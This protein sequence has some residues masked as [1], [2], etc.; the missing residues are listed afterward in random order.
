MNVMNPWSPYGSG[1]V[2]TSTLSAYVSTLMVVVAFSV[3]F[4]M[5]RCSN[6]CVTLPRTAMQIR[7]A[8]RPV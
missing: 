4:G 7:C 3:A 6:V 2:L 8:E 1:A 5:V